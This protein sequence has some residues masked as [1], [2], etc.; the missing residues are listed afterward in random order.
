[1]SIALPFELTYQRETLMLFGGIG[2]V[3]LLASLIGAALRWRAGPGHA[4]VDNLNARIRA[5]WV[6]VLLIGFAFLCGAGGVI[7]LF[8]LIS[9]FALREY[10]TLTDTRRG[11]HWALA[12]SFFVALPMQ[13]LLI[14]RDWYGLFSILIPV[15]GFLLLPIIAAFG[16]DTT[17]F[18]KRAAQTQWGL[19]ICVYCISH[20]PALLTLDIPGYADRQLLLVTFLI[21]VVQSSDVLQ[22]VWGK[23]CGRHKVAPSLSPS[24]TWE[25]LIGGTL[26][27]T[28]LGASLWWIT[29]FSPCQAAGMALLICAMGFL[30]GLVMSAIKRDRGVKDWGALIEGHGGMLDRLDSVCF[31]APVFFHLTRYFFE[32]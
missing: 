1:M 18:L 23:L 25:G 5:W 13:Y 9:F 20:V 8:A 31:A 26:S 6:M 19:M 14:G 3:L 7:L 17:N 11:D 10:L 28:A 32:P 29:P 30:G 2:G 15:Y 12:I 16:S 4:V 27:A 22:Y 21:L 24:K